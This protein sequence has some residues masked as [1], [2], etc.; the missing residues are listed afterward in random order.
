MWY[1]DHAPVDGHI[2]RAKMDL[3]GYQKREKKRRCIFG[4]KGDGGDLR[5][6]RESD[7]RQNTWYGIL[8]G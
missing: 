8:K 4:G 2:A 3:M 1:V 6:F 7:Y 5:R